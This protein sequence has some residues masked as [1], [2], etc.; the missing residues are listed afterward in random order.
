MKEETSIRVNGLG[1]NFVRLGP[2]SRDMNEIEGSGDDGP[3]QE[4]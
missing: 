2:Q 3:S 1:M 4:V